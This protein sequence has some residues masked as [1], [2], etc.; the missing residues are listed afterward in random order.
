MS[1]T[2]KMQ[3]MLGIPQAWFASAV[4]NDD[5]DDELRIAFDLDGAIADDESVYAGSN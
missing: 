2:L 3:W 4:V 1:G 5:G